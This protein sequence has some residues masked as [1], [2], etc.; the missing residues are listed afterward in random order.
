MGHSSY[1]DSSRSIRATTVG[2]ATKSRDEIFTQNKL[3]Q[4]HAQ[5]DPKGIV[6]RES[7]DSDTHPNTVP[8]QFYLDVTGSMRD[9]PHQLIKDGLPTMIGSLI[10]NG[11]KDVALMFGAIGDHECDRCPLQIAQ[12]ESGD[13][14]LDMWLER[15]YLEGGGGGN[16]GESYLLA[17]YFAANHVK[18]DAFLKRG[19]KGYVFTV[20]DEPTLRSLPMTAVRELMGESAVGQGSYGAR[21]LLEAAQVQNH[22][23]HIHI[24]HGRSVD[25]GWKDLMGQNLIVIN[26]HN[27]LAK[28]ISDTVL[29]YEGMTEYSSLSG[30]SVE[31]LPKTEVGESLAK[32]EEIYL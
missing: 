24:D 25:R 3:R 27:Q 26:D 23:F 13:A 5:M 31:K 8:I 1:S 9:I 4:I 19:R 17:W 6:F 14:E 12:F 30:P 11:V 28:T 7:C 32:A 2:Y 15:V 20:G 21:Q 29:S 22:V 16:A 10:Q 18:T